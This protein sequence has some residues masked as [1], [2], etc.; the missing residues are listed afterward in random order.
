MQH[1]FEKFGCCGMRDATLLQRCM[2][3]AVLLNFGKIRLVLWISRSG[4]HISIST[5]AIRFINN[6]ISLQRQNYFYNSHWP[7]CTIP[8][9]F[10]FYVVVYV[11]IIRYNSTMRNLLFIVIRLW[12]YCSWSRASLD[13]R[14]SATW[15]R[16]SKARPSSDVIRQMIVGSRNGIIIL[17]WQNC[18]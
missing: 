2:L 1:E 13:A 8:Q 14:A 4:A 9:S 12:L 10:T 15:E 16:I 3:H 11:G 5:S 6:G 7:Q 18:W 17:E